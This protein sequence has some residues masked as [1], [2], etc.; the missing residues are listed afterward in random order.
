RN[1]I[2]ACLPPRLSSRPVAQRRGG[3]WGIG[4]YE[5]SLFLRRGFLAVGACPERAERVEWAARNDSSRTAG[6]L[7]RFD[8][9]HV[10]AAATD[11]AA[12]PLADL[13][14]RSSVA[15]ANQC[16]CRTNL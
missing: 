1:R 14:V 12:H 15:L 3:T 10:T 2:H 7:H 5:R 4:R 11:I 6:L 8:D 16:R 13:G 9:S